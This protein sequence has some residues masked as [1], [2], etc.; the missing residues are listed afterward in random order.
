MINDRKII[1]RIR[2]T[3]TLRE[4]IKSCKDTITRPEVT[5]KEVRRDRVKE[6]LRN[7][8]TQ[9]SIR[10]VCKEESSRMKI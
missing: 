10:S 2:E 6:E 1:R 9:Y 7:K 8:I 4:V 5:L 3:S